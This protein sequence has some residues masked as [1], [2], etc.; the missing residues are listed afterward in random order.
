MTPMRNGQG[1]AGK[2]AIVDI[3]ETD[4][5]RRGALGD[6][7]ELLLCIEAIRRAAG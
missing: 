7:G 6:H 3:G 5:G 2:T 1:L 4:Y